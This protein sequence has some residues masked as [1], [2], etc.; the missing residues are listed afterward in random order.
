MRKV[1]FALTLLIF[2]NSCQ[3]KGLQNKGLQNKGLQNKGL[4]NKGLQNKGLDIHFND[5]DAKMI[6]D[7]Q[8]KMMSED[9]CQL[10]RKAYKTTLYL[11]L[12][13]EGNEGQNVSILL[14][15]KLLE[16]VT[17]QDILDITYQKDGKEDINM[18][19]LA[20]LSE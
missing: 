9:N 5:K 6:V 10:F 7:A 1:F 11:K 16:N 18:L 4:Q 14:Y 13:G 8:C 17:L 15:E 2:I 12:K 3:N 20:I 19:W